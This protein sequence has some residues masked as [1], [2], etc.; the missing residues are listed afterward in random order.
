[1]QTHLQAPFTIERRRNGVDGFYVPPA[2]APARV[3]P[4]AKGAGERRVRRAA[5]DGLLRQI[6]TVGF[7]ERGETGLRDPRTVSQE[8]R[9]LRLA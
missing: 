1:M 6:C 5:F 9:G 7:N 8:V 3:G 4:V 2:E